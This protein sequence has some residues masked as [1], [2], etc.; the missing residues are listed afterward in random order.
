[1]ANKMIQCDGDSSFHGK[2][3]SERS[4]DGLDRCAAVK[5]SAVPPFRYTGSNI[6]LA[7]AHK[8]TLQPR[9]WLR[10]DGLLLVR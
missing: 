2:T 3:P 8:V 10:L 5:A 6:G 7:Q 4:H 9:R 1:M